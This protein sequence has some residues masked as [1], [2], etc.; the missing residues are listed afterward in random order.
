MDLVERVLEGDRRAV[1]R[2]ISMVEDGA[3]GL[4]ELS[5]GL[6]PHTGHA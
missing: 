4:E 2:A 5:A 3:D 1:A 6:F